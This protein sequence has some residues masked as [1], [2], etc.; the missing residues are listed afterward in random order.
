VT[1]P[2]LGHLDEDEATMLNPTGLCQCGC[3]SPTPIA[4]RSERGY[5][6]GE[7]L[8][9]IKGHQEPQPHCRNGHEYSPENIYWHPTLGRRVCRA[10]QSEGQRRHR[11]R[12]AAERAIGIV[13][14]CPRC[15]QERAAAEMQWHHRDKDT[16]LFDVSKGHHYTPELVSA[17]IAKCDRI[18]RSCHTRLHQLER[19]AHGR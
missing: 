16:K 4:K 12:R 9:F 3:G 14:R 5:K 8:R 11:E 19:N 13:E 15:G 18:C 2:A 6:R 10:C 7:P 17:E 1:S